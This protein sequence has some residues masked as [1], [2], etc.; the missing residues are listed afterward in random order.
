MQHI[1]AQ[2]LRFKAAM[3]AS[4][5]ACAAL[6]HTNAH[7]VIKESRAVADADAATAEAKRLGD[8]LARMRQ[9][10][11]EVRDMYAAVKV[12]ITWAHKYVCENSQDNN[13]CQHVYL[14]CAVSAAVSH[15]LLQLQHI[16]VLNIS[17]VCSERSGRLGTAASCR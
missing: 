12:C 5:A 2:L 6:Q 14:N 11:A 10:L 3:D 17:G 1:E 13:Y 4:E 15:S 16:L 8:S 7:L 9:E